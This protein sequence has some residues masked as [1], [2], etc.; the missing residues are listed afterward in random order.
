MSTIEGREVDATTR[1]SGRPKTDE[2]NLIPSTWTTLL[3]AQRL[4]AS[5]ELFKT[6]GDLGFPVENAGK[7]IGS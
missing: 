6:L 5:G 3:A 2:G 7:G 4:I 1:P